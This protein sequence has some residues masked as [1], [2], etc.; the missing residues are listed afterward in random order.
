[1]D[2]QPKPANVK[3]PLP[4]LT[5]IIDLLDY[6]DVS[7]YDTAIQREY[8]SVYYALLHKRDRL[9]LRE[10][11]VKILTAKS[12]DDRHAARMRY[13]QEKRLLESF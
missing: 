4:L 13:L 5:E 3:I 7:L 2:N 12:E 6:W 1:M 8:D 11:Y 9:G 10:T